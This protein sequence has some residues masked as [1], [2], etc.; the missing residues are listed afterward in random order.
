MSKHKL[1]GALKK[2]RSLDDGRLF[3]ADSCDEESGDSHGECD[4][5]TNSHVNPNF[6]FETEK[7]SKTADNHPGAARCREMPSNIS[8]KPKP[9]V[10]MKDTSVRP[11]KPF[12]LPRPTMPPPPPPCGSYSSEKWIRKLTTTR[13][14]E[15]GHSPPKKAETVSRGISSCASNSFTKAE[16]A[17]RHRKVSPIKREILPHDQSKPSPRPTPPARPPPPLTSTKAKSC[18]PDGQ[19]DAS[20]DQPGEHHQKDLPPPPT[21]EKTIQTAS[22]APQPAANPPAPSSE[23][24]PTPPPKTQPEQD[25]DMKAESACEGA[26][27][28]MIDPSPQP[29]T[30]SLNSSTSSE[31]PDAADIVQLRS[32]RCVVRQVP[33]TPAKTPK[34]KN[35]D[36]QPSATEQC[37]KTK[38]EYDGEA[39]EEDEG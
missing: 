13:E 1:R 19:S 18:S 3:F 25:S 14:H 38:L 16:L 8:N 9:A 28:P 2:R 11:R 32:G 4:T 39:S 30:S 21:Q 35:N 37:D 10:P 24:H 22:D 12:R 23:T 36:Q 15:L 5:T 17:S 6:R 33:K 7:V 20:K 26:M 29:E 34:K 31:N 27:A